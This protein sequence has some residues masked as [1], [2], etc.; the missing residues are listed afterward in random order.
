MHE[1]IK[2]YLRKWKMQRKCFYNE[3]RSPFF[4]AI[5]SRRYRALNDFSLLFVSAARDA[6]SAASYT[7]RATSKPVKKASYERTKNA[8]RTCDLPM[9]QGTT[10]TQPASPSFLCLP[11]SPPLF[12]PPRPRPSE[13]FLASRSRPT[14][15]FAA[16]RIKAPH[17]FMSRPDFTNGRIPAPFRSSLAIVPFVD[18]PPGKKITAGL[19]MTLRIISYKIRRL[20]VNTL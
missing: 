14:A 19:W 2:I 17:G 7:P 3:K 6:N 18:A 1:I 10:R 13:R 15:P 4:K 16:L 20:G 11:P 5:I 12:P 8:W 9:P